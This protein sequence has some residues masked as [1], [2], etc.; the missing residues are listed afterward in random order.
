MFDYVQLSPARY[1]ELTARLLESFSPKFF[2]T[3]PLPFT[4]PPQ[5]LYW[6]EFALKKAG[7]L[8]PLLPGK[9]N[10]KQIMNVSDAPLFTKRCF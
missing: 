1:H 2:T 10:R 4:L 9:D 6:L 7:L 5:R 3:S 8:L